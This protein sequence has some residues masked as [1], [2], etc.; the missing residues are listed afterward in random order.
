MPSSSGADDA[1]TTQRCQPE[2]F[3]TS[4]PPAVEA[5]DSSEPCDISSEDSSGFC[6]MLT[7]H[8]FL[9]YQRG[10][11]VD[12]DK[13]SL[14]VGHYF[15]TVC[16]M[17]SCFDSFTN[18]LRT[19]IQAAMTTSRLIQSCV[20]SISA[21]HLCLINPHWSINRLEYL[22][23]AISEVKRELDTVL[24]LSRSSYSPSS[25]LVAGT[26]T[27]DDENK[28][29]RLLL[30]VLLL[31]VTTSWHVSSGLGLE[32]IPGARALLRTWLARSFGNG[33]QQQQQQ[34]G[35]HR[36]LS[37][38]NFYVGLQAYWEAMASFLIDQ[39][40]SQIDFL[41]ASLATFPAQ[42]PQPQQIHI[43]P[44]TGLSAIPWLYLARS[45][46]LIRMKRRLVKS[47]VGNSNGGMAATTGSSASR[48]QSDM[49][50]L[51]RL[52]SR[53]RILTA[54]ILSYDMPC[55]EQIEETYDDH[56]P[57]SHLKDLALCCQLVAL[58]EI[59][60]AFD[61][62]DESKAILD[63]I[64]SVITDT[65]KD[66]RMSQPQKRKEGE[67]EEEEGDGQTDED[68][69][70]PSSSS[71]RET[72]ITK[73]STTII[74]LLS[75][76]PTDSGTR[77]LHHLLLL[78][79][80]SALLPH[81]KWDPPPPALVSMSGSGIVYDV[82]IDANAD[83]NIDSNIN[84]PR[85][86]ALP[87][88]SPS[89][90]SD[91]SPS[92]ST[93]CVALWQWRQ[94]VLD[95]ITFLEQSLRLDALR[96]VRLILQQV[97]ARSDAILHK[98]SYDLDPDHHHRRRRRRSDSSSLAP[99]LLSGVSAGGGVVMNCSSPLEWESLLHW[100]DVMEDADLVFFF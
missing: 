3:I 21:A 2:G 65:H 84:N 76:M 74:T 33:Q 43:N 54:Q 68:N 41:F 80:G 93:S 99:P 18:P 51:R 85:M 90:F 46:C 69:D 47:R 55:D 63:L 81:L 96:K 52:E 58:L 88:S 73:L 7:R 30:G 91:T 50:N 14:L 26:T 72:L 32:H 45:G 29:D 98:Y 49:L 36:L 56:T 57:K 78:A 95:R 40:P 61:I 25:S 39:E 19:E 13:Q 83:T 22:T 60:R 82:N 15:S 77:S 35:D 28:L 86:D 44:W 71:C 31:G 20:M 27:A 23:A 94:I 42:Q 37:L 70:D 53:A 100:I 38:L 59:H 48:C 34:Q 92:S 79:S 89:S 6:T 16:T 97:W 67:V 4:W 5:I 87:S 1:S 8:T 62:A 24:L 11:V 12:L 10:L 66:Y 64:K 75:R 9:P 17:L